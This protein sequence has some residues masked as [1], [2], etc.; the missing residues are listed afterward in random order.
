MN[1]S[2]PDVFSCMTTLPYCCKPAIRK[3]LRRSHVC[4]FCDLA[5][6]NKGSNIITTHPGID[7][8]QPRLFYAGIPH[9][10]TLRR[11]CLKRIR[12]SMWL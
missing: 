11:L 10:L 6:I 4:P 5:A 8:A 12:K 7:T 2:S 3:T 9:L 1:T